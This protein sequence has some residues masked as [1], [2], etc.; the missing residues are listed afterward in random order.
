MSNEKP[1]IRAMAACAAHMLGAL[2]LL[3][4]VVTRLTTFAPFGIGPRSYAIGAGLLFLGSI[5]MSACPCCGSRNCE[6]S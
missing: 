1:G 3:G 5:A 4:A 2:S 6:K